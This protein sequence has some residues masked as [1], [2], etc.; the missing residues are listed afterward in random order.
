VP[1]ARHRLDEDEAD[2]VGVKQATK[3]RLRIQ[4]MPLDR[5]GILVIFD[6][7]PQQRV[8]VNHAKRSLEVAKPKVEESGFRLARSA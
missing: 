2:I 8:Q 5:P 4:K 1:A 7:S 3:A 6:R